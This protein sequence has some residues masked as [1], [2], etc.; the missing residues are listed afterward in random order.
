M[1]GLVIDNKA[2]N[3]VITLQARLALLTHHKQQLRLRKR[4]RD[5]IIIGVLSASR[6]LHLY[7]Q[8][9][10]F[11]FYLQSDEDRSI[12]VSTHNRRRRTADVTRGQDTPTRTKPRPPEHRP[13]PPA[14]IAF[15]VYVFSYQCFYTYV[16][17][18]HRNSHEQHRYICRNSQQYKGQ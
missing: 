6:A 13:R 7:S 18:Q 2:H 3:H 12:N 1:S 14:L 10:V 16:S 9:V 8:S 5:N 15:F 4:E 17:M 11:G